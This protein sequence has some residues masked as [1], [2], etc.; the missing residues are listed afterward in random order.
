[1]FFVSMFSLEAVDYDSNLERLVI[2]FDQERAKRG[3]KLTKNFK[4]FFRVVFLQRPIG[5]AHKKYFLPHLP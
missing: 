2:A 4:Y 1:M 5:F 3:N